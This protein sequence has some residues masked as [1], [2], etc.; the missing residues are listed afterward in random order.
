MW[1]ECLVAWLQVVDQ[2]QLLQQLQQHHFGLPDAVLRRAVSH[3][4]DS[5]RLWRVLGKLI[6]GEAI[7]VATVGGSVTGAPNVLL[8]LDETPLYAL[9][10]RIAHPTAQLARQGM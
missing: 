4:G 1:G 6:R 10:N 7:T 2:R 9:L 3:N 5:E 8:N